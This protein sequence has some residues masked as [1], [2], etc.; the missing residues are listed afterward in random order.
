M[1]LDLVEEGVVKTDTF[2]EKIAELSYSDT[3][4]A[5]QFISLFSTIR[6][7]MK[8]NSEIF[9]QKLKKLKE[10]AAFKDDKESLDEIEW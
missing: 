5:N 10:K 4:L 3:Q 2:L 7:E 8:T 6:E 1:F 9:M